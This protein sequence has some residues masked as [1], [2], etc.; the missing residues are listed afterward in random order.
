MFGKAARV[1]TECIYSYLHFLAI[2]VFP[3]GCKRSIVMVA[4]HLQEW[5]VDIEV[6]GSL[7]Q[8]HC[9][10]CPVTASLLDKAGAL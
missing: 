6:S 2:E 8:L 7:P 4:T 3:V 1:R 5:I 9:C 10:L